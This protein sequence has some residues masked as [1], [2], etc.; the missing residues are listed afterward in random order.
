M[1][2]EHGYH[3]CDYHC[4]LMSLP[5]AFGTRVESIPTQVPIRPFMRIFWN[6]DPDKMN[7]GIQW[8][9]NVNHPDD[10]F[11]SIPWAQF[12]RVTKVKGV[13]FW[14]LQRNIRPSDLPDLERSGL[15]CLWFDGFDALA[16]IVNKMDLIVSVDSALVHLA[17]AM[18]KPTWALIAANP[19]WRWM[20]NRVDS[21]WYSSAR[22]F[23][24]QRLGN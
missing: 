19:D 7:V 10:A 13:K 6:T 24:R 21:P 4:P 12:D 14:G 8:A 11:R 22:L 16:A 5:Y 9:G 1:T 15:T 17:G 20:L 23:R 3:D 2:D 18:G